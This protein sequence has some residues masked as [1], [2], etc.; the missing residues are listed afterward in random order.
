MVMKNTTEI[1]LLKNGL[2]PKLYAVVMQYEDFD[3][4][5]LKVAAPSKGDFLGYIVCDVFNGIRRYNTVQ[6][7]CDDID[8]ELKDLKVESNNCRCC[9]VEIES[10]KLH[11]Q[12]CKEDMVIKQFESECFDSAGD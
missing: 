2:D 3:I 5:T 4:C 12:D 7:A 10:G 11:C 9:G 1:T 8:N 6:E